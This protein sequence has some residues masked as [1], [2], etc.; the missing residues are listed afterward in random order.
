MVEEAKLMRLFQGAIDPYRIGR[1]LKETEDGFITNGH[2]GVRKELLECFEYS[3][4]IRG[5]VSS[6]V[7]DLLEGVFRKREGEEVERNVAIY[8]DFQ[9]YAV[10]TE[11]INRRK[12]AFYVLDVDVLFKKV[13]VLK[14]Y[15]DFI[16]ALVSGSIRVGKVRRRVYYVEV[17]R[18]NGS[19]KVESYF[20]WY[21][22]GSEG[23][24]KVI[25]VCMGCIC[26]E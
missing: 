22:K 10:R 4:Y 20:V 2:W 18:K 3:Q 14:S 15:V 24:D 6:K 7:N 8:D 19:R 23:E 13:L 17:L 25:A 26:S 5:M 21:V 11:V 12:L 1:V 16:E 9:W